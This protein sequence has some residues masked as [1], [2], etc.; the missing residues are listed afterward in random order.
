MLSEKHANA[1]NMRVCKKK[2][3]GS[4]AV[5]DPWA[6]ES[7]GRKIAHCAQGPQRKSG[8]HPHHWKQSVLLYF[9]QERSTHPICKM[10]MSACTINYAML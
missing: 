1:E 3:T 9:L 5:E 2:L 10:R 8:Q 6:A 4:A 7:C